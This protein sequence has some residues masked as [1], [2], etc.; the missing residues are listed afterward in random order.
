MRHRSRIAPRL[1]APRRHSLGRCP[2]STCHP[3]QRESPLDRMQGSSALAPA[4]FPTIT[5]TA[6][7]PLRNGYERMGSRVGWPRTSPDQRLARSQHVWLNWRLVDKRAPSVAAEVGEAGGR[8]GSTRVASGLMRGMFIPRSV[9]LQRGSF[10]FG[11]DTSP[12]PHGP[13]LASH[14]ISRPAFHMQAMFY[15]Q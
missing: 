4:F 10:R 15:G 1:A 14:R 9:F 11:R 5:L 6:G 8:K 13:R 3:L 12:S 2:W 7:A